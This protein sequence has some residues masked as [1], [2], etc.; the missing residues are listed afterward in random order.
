[1]SRLRDIQNALQ[2]YL[3]FDQPE[4]L[5][6]ITETK[7][8]SAEVRLE[9]YRYAYQHRL[10]DTLKVD[11]PTLQRLLGEK[12][13]YDMAK[14]Y[15]DVYPSR[16]R[17]LR[18]FGKSLAKFLAET[19]PYNKRGI[20]AELA[21]L[22]WLFVDAF[23]AQDAKPLQVADFAKISSEKWPGLT[24]QFH[25]SLFRINP[26]WNSMEIW[27]ANDQGF[28]LPKAKKQQKKSAWVIWRSNYA[29]RYLKLS[30]AT[31]AQAL[32]ALISGKNFAKMCGKITDAHPDVTAAQWLHRWVL[33]G[34]IKSGSHN[35]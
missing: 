26:Q 20:Y 23:D 27:E 6:K 1:M 32:D 30:S 15:L 28:P 17:S 8:V 33:E 34:F 3:R 16:H 11:F 12:R 22:E 4:I 2:N 35:V 29:I 18:A 14:Q 10:I 9:I 31:E 21:T 25:P 13:F 24:F 7:A 19:S 5:S